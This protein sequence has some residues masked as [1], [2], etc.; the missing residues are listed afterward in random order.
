MFDVTCM[1]LGGAFLFVPTVLSVDD[2]AAVIL[3]KANLHIG[4]VFVTLLQLW[5]QSKQNLCS[6][7][8]F[9]LFST[10]PKQI[11]QSSF[12]TIDCEADMIIVI[13]PSTLSAD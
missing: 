13:L 10:S 11:Q 7:A 12:G 3:L 2:V 9:P 6:Q 5:M 1:S 4:H 8:I